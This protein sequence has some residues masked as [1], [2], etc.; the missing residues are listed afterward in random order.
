M[1]P[2]RRAPGF[3]QP[4]GK[5][6]EPNVQGDHPQPAGTSGP[7]GAGSGGSRPIPAGIAATIR[8]LTGAAAADGV[9]S[10]RAMLLG[11]GGKP[12]P[13]QF[14]VALSWPADAPFQA[15]F[16]RRSGRPPAGPGQVMIDRAS[17]RHGHYTVGDH[18]EVAIN[19]Q[20]RPFTITGITGYGSADSVGGG[21]MAIFSLAAAQ[22]LFDLVGRYSQIDVK[23]AAGVSAAQ[24]RS[25]V[26]EILPL[27]V[28]AVTA[29]DAALARGLAA[30]LDAFG[31]S[32][33]A[34][35]L[36]VPP[37]GTAAAFGAGL[38]IT[39][40]AAVPPAWRA[41]G[42]AP[43][44]ALRDSVA[45]PAGFPAGRL[46]S[47]FALTAAGIGLVLA[48]LFAVAPL[49]VT[50]AGAGACFL[51]I[52]VL[53]PLFARPLAFAVGL[54]L[55]VLRGR[56]G[57]LA[58]GN[59]MRN[60]RRTSASA[61]ALMTGLALIVATSVLVAS[62]RSVLRAQITSDSKTSFYV[63]A[64]SAD[65]GITPR[66]A[67][68]LAQVRGVRGGTEVRTT[69]ATVAGAAHQNVDGVDP[70]PIRE[71]TG[72][73]TRSGSLA[74]LADGKLLVSQSA[75]AGHHWQAGDLVTITFGSYGTA[76]LPIG[77]IFTN[78]GPLSGYLISNTA[79]AAETGIRADSV[80]LVRAG[81][82]ARRA[83]L[84]P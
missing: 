25:R 83:L 63:Q 59:A 80:D 75:V 58:R 49:A 16:T 74:S 39:V 29:A 79:F 42:V 5:G 2:S 14:S 30:L 31:L 11:R 44:Q 40:V 70:G 76:R 35:G 55:A 23:A 67:A 82:S 4:A 53:A 48:G 56:T 19:G 57:A 72:V 22:H 78:P 47:G 62:V 41:T 36:V 71:F 32:L 27:G 33:P 52:T 20:A 34:A 24:L 38:V 7:A 65:A 1:S 81:A 28:R 10:G 84:R 73:R 61:A 18:I 66:L 64:T 37:A 77:G 51:G 9:V 68:A 46:I 8:G 43:V 13:G 3:R 17:A 60:P 6:I 54:P 21:S 45:A 12:L 15:I 50:A 69:D 26:A